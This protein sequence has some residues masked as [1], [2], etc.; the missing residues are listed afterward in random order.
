M[1]RK[2]C[3]VKT[4][5][6]DPVSQAQV[7][8]LV[9]NVRWGYNSRFAEIGIWGRLANDDLAAISS[10]ATT[11]RLTPVLVDLHTYETIFGYLVVTGSGTATWSIVISMTG[12]TSNDLSAT[13][14]N[15]GAVELVKLSC[16]PG[17]SDPRTC[18][19]YVIIERTSGTGTLIVHYI[20]LYGHRTAALADGPACGATALAADLQSALDKAERALYQPRP[21]IG[22]FGSYTI[23]V[24]KTTTFRWFEL[25]DKNDDD[26]TIESTLRAKA[27]IYESVSA[28]GK[29]WSYHYDDNGGDSD[30]VTRD[31]I[32]ADRYDEVGITLDGTSYD[33]ASPYSGGLIA[34]QA[35]AD[36]DRPAVIAWALERQATTA[37]KDALSPSVRPMPDYQIRTTEAARAVGINEIAEYVHQCTWYQGGNCAGGLATDAGKSYS[38]TTSYATVFNGIMWVHQDA[39]SGAT[40][41]TNEYQVAIRCSNGGAATTVDCR[42]TVDG[43]TG[44]DTGIALGGGENYLVFDVSVSSIDI[45]GYGVLCKVELQVAAARTVA[46]YSVHIS[47]RGGAY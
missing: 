5:D 3:K 24:S 8:Q 30:S 31:A 10:T 2:Y 43:Q 45:T 20:G 21:V 16:T 14:T 26:Q 40:W 11:Y 28:A 37:L 36:A 15:P 34:T 39:Q 12:G 9:R 13:V 7:R 47:R 18:I 27:L 19:P 32:G 1:T 44:T 23:P 22:W 4:Q 41:G 25:L 46:V 29:T 6:A 33:L 42:L 17:S 35:S 38:L